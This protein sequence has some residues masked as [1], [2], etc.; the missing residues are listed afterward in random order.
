MPHNLVEPHGGALV[1]LM[2]DEGEAE[3]LRDASRDWTSLDLSDR[4]I[5]DLELLL[6]GGFSPLTGF[7]TRAEYEGVCKDMRLPDGTLWPIPVVLDVSEELGS[8]LEPGAKLAL[9]DAEGV[10]LAVLN[11]AD[12]WTPD[13]EAEAELVFGTRNTEH[14]G[15]NELLNDTGPIYVGGRLTG[16]QLPVHYDFRPLRLSP[17][18]VREEFARLGWRKIVAFQTRNPMHR[19]HVELTLRAAKEVEANLLY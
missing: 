13:R 15:V 8:T 2:V 18:E 4:Q 14:P 16:V 11:V 6:N 7:M 9:R 1:D 10:M 3:K 12:V 19:A 17:H 5:C